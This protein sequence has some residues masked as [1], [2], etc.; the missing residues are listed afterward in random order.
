MRYKCKESWKDYEEYSRIFNGIFATLCTCDWAIVHLFDKM[1]YENYK[2]KQ[3][4][5]MIKNKFRLKVRD[6]SLSESIKRKIDENHEL[7][8]AIYRYDRKELIDFFCKSKINIPIT[9]DNIVK[10]INYYTNLDEK[11]KKETF[12]CENLS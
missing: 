7:A 9:N 1:A 11:L 6:S 5:Y 4:D 8:K 2:N 10:I 3:W 12:F